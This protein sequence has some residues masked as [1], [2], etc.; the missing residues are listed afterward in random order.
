MGQPCRSTAF[1]GSRNVT[2]LNID[3]DL[4]ELI[5]RTI[6]SERENENGIGQVDTMGYADW[7]STNN[8]RQVCGGQQDSIGCKPKDV[9]REG[10]KKP[11]CPDDKH[12]FLSYGY[13]HTERP[14]NTVR[15]AAVQN[16]G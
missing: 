10:R 4:R 15:H 12:R 7:Y 11:N 2:V 3:F 14:K 13:E 16:S 1:A 9:L 6:K 5:E 8:V